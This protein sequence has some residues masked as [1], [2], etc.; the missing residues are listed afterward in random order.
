VYDVAAKH[1]KASTLFDTITDAAA[2]VGGRVPF[3]RPDILP[4]GT[5]APPPPPPMTL[6]ELIAEYNRGL[7]ADALATLP[8]NVVTQIA[9]L[10]TVTL[11]TPGVNA[12]TRGDVNAII[13][14]ARNQRGDG[15]KD[16]IIYR[17][18]TEMRDSTP[19]QIV[20]RMRDVPIELVEEVQRLAPLRLVQT[21]RPNNILIGDRRRT[22]SHDPA[23]FNYDLIQS[24]GTP[25]RTPLAILVSVR[26]TDGR[27]ATFVY[28]TA[29]AQSMF[30]EGMGVK[31]VSVDKA[32]DKKHKWVATF[33]DGTK[34]P[35]GDRRYEDY[36]QH[37]DKKRRTAYR[38]RHK[39][40]LETGDPRRAGYLSYYLLWGD[41]TDL[42]E[43]VMAYEQKTKK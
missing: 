24:A 4:T 39:K 5:N 11:R 33:S 1:P 16:D 12:L 13:L 27:Q 42:S 10:P 37:G 22:E 31:L 21:V 14:A 30:G 40:D 29:R 6:Q 15:L 32:D 2:V 17:I 36:T 38:S 19:E 26:L 20:E 23:G 35:F 8:I 41:S 43:N 34:T 7:R 9:A 28:A 3:N 18:A 25:I